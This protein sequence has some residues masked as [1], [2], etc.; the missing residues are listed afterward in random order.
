MVN[1]KRPRPG[2][3][4]RYSFYCNSIK[5]V[6]FP[7]RKPKQG[8]SYVIMIIPVLLRWFKSPT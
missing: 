7:V 8:T 5:T 6:L 4:D 3:V 1:K 2:S